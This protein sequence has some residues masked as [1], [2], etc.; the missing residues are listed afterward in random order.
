MSV[1]APGVCGCFQILENHDY[2]IS[3]LKNGFIK[4]YLKTEKRKKIK[5]EGGIF[6]VKKNSIVVFL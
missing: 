1:I 6:Q 3:I 5:I 2:F 4:L